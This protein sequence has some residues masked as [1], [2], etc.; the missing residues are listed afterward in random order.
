MDFLVF[1][2]ALLALMYVLLVLT[3]KE[4]EPLRNIEEFDRN[5]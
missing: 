1:C 4:S 3:A 2:L 5:G